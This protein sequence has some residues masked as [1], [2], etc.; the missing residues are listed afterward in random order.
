MNNVI[1]LRVIHNIPG[2][3]RLRLNINPVSIIAMEKMVRNHPGISKFQYNQHTKSVLVNYDS[4]D[5]SQEEI[6]IR[7]AVF[8][9]LENNL[10]PVRVF[11]DMKVREMS[12]SA[13]FS[14]FIIL[15]SIASRLIPNSLGFRNI[16]DWAA[17]IGTAYS[18]I[19]HGYNEFTERGN[20]DPEVLSVIYLFT[21]FTQ[22]KF[23]PSTIF[24]WIATFGRHLVR[25]SSKNVEIKPKLLSSSEEDNPQY[26]VVITPINEL[27]G[28]KMFF[29]F[30]PMVIINAAMRNRGNFEGT[31][32]N[33]IRKVSQ[34]H[35]E[36]LEGFGKFKNGIPIR[37]QYNKN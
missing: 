27:P 7:V 34:Q 33:E 13:F 23:L 15:L 17:G 16:I 28:R 26:E 31:L 37:I 30:L 25:Y 20:F 9:S 35:G 4:E 29:N 6:I 24:T 18:I 10:Q 22:G 12:D 21:S 8:I 32:I 14:G 36:V 19:D 5:T 11:S 1:V 2:R 3:V